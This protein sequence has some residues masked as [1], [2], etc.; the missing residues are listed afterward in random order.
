MTCIQEIS[1]SRENN[2]TVS[3]LP[4][5]A[6]Y[7]NYSIHVLLVICYVVS[8]CI[9][10]VANALLVYIL[11]LKKKSTSSFDYQLV[12]L[13]ISHFVASVIVIPYV[14]ILDVGQVAPEQFRNITCVFTEGLQIFFIACGVSLIMLCVISYNRVIATLYPYKRHLLMSKR[15]VV[16]VDIVSWIIMV[17]TMFPSMLAQTYFP[18]V[19][20]CIQDL[21][22]V[23]LVI[24]PI[25]YR[26]GQLVASLLLPLVW[27]LATYASIRLSLRRRRH[28]TGQ[29]QS[30]GNMTLA[31]ASKLLGYQILTLCIGWFPFMT[32]WF[33]YGATD[34]IQGSCQSQVSSIK[35]HRLSILFGVINAAADPLI[36]LIGA[37]DNKKI[38]VDMYR[39]VSP[40]FKIS[41]TVR[42]Q[43]I[44][45]ANFKSYI[46][47][48]ED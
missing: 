36:Y 11:V 24:K 30:Q 2:G 40:F 5:P 38:V 16:V 45:L 25:S 4:Y 41:H 39:K 33:V 29:A 32:Y 21:Q 42:R 48:V 7:F 20:L 28:I 6:T 13:C 17:I 15:M 46:Q 19:R 12:N 44:Q 3:I 14:F 8:I 10:L 31:K 35:W 27:V 9:S 18:E 43:S 22:S 47:T 1:K 26:M 34:L 37:N 23:G